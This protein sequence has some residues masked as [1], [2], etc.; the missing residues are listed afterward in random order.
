MN[1]LE[2]YQKNLKEFLYNNY[3][4]FSLAK[5]SWALILS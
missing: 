3:S 2:K 1:D 4:D 5:K